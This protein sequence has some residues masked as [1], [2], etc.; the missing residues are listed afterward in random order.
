MAESKTEL[1]DMGD[2]KDQLIQ[3]AIQTQINCNFAEYAR[4]R[5]APDQTKPVPLQASSTL[6]I[7]ADNN[8]NEVQTVDLYYDDIA[9]TYVQKGPQSAMLE[10]IKKL[11]LPMFKAIS[12][13]VNTKGRIYVEINLLSSDQGNKK[14]GI[15][16]HKKIA[17]ELQALVDLNL[18][19][20]DTKHYVYKHSDH[21]TK[22]NT[23]DDLYQEIAYE[24]SKL[25]RAVFAVKVVG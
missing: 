3:V 12:K 13:A 7:G 22:A 14:D 9:S 1:L 11:T 10:H 21:P 17:E 19:G 5:K 16:W 4:Q 2:P 25:A 15:G 8:L 6:Y 24:Y 18:R 23:F 20:K